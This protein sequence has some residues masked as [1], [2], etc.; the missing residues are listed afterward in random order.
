MHGH[1]GPWAHG[2]KGLG[3]G[4]GPLRP[5]IF[6]KNAYVLTC[7]GDD[8]LSNNN[9]MAARVV[10]REFSIY[11]NTVKYG[12]LGFWDFCAHF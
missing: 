3:P 10:Y 2:L 8:V 11:K 5:C 12:F 9:I 1:M 4:L 7:F 6:K